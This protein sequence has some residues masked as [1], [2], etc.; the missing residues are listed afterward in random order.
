ML[1]NH[2]VTVALAASGHVGCSEVGKIKVDVGSSHGKV[3]CP[4]TIRDVPRPRYVQ[5]AYHLYGVLL[6]SAILVED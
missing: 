2:V 6:D 5:E 3:I 4:Y 1:I